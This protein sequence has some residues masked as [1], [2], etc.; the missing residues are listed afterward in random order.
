MQSSFSPIP[1]DEAR[2]LS[3]LQ[4]AYLGDTVWE[5]MVREHSFS[6]GRHNVHKMHQATVAFVNAHAQ[7]RLMENVTDR[8]TEDESDIA[9]R[10]RN[11]HAHHPAPKNQDPADY[12]T[13][14]AMETL[15]GYLYATG[16]TGRLE[17]L[18]G[19]ALEE[20]ENA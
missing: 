19:K 6:G 16:N 10:G 12:Q 9:K 13:A 11:A 5:L 3:P 20:N 7:A 1:P 14:T 2:L 15:V 17:E 8:L 4:L 18:F